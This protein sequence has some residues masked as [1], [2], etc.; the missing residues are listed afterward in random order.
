MLKTSSMSASCAAILSRAGP[1]DFRRRLLE[2]RLYIRGAHCY[3]QLE[4][5]SISHKIIWNA[6]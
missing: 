4:I 1:G 6:Y 5:D 2:L 3:H